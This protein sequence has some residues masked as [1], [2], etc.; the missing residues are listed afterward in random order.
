MRTY[1]VTNPNEHI[2]RL[3][4]VPQAALVSPITRPRRRG[5]LGLKE[6]QLRDIEGIGQP[7]TRD[8]R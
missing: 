7:P 1:M 5:E 6:L 2:D 3:I 4:S 8:L